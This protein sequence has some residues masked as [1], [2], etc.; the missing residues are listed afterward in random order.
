MDKDKI[1]NDF[2]ATLMDVAKELGNDVDYPAVQ[3]FVRE[4]YLLANKVPP[5]MD[6]WIK[7]RKGAAV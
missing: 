6:E 7:E 3:E 5:S 2:L 4:T 1:T